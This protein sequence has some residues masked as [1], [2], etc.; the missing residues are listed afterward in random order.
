MRYALHY[1]GLD[2]IR[3]SRALGPSFSTAA[4]DR[5]NAVGRFPQRAGRSFGRCEKELNDLDAF[6]R[7]RTVMPWLAELEKMR[8]VTDLGGL[9][10]LKRAP[11]QILPPSSFWKQL[12]EQRRSG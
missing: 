6:E 9:E 5:T 12:G 11:E 8:R 2:C 10:P 1:A 7:Q 4:E 3:D